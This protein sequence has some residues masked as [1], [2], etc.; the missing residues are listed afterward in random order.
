MCTYSS[1][2]IG[3]LIQGEKREEEFKKTSDDERKRR[4]KRKRFT[5]KHRE[6]Q[7][8]DIHFKVFYEKKE[9]KARECERE[10]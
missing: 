1:T 3:G 7:E 10:V 9:K 8:E 6:D 5:E 4:E 2:T